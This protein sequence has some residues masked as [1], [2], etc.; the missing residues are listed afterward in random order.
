MRYFRLALTAIALWPAVTFAQSPQSVAV[1][2]QILEIEAVFGDCPV[3][4]DSA[5]RPVTRSCLD[6]LYRIARE[7]CSRR[8]W[9][10]GNPSR[11]SGTPPTLLT[12]I[13]CL[14]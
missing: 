5:G 10:N 7:E 11:I 13:S 14:P 3:S 1:Q 2:P 8:G 4:S 12:R 9:S 6:D